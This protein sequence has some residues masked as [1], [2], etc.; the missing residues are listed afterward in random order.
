MNSGN[1]L[2]PLMNALNLL[3]RK[4]KQNSFVF[5]VSFDFFL[6]SVFVTNWTKLQRCVSLLDHWCNNPISDYLFSY[7]YQFKLDT[8]E[9]KVRVVRSII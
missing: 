8:I 7:V 6:Q 9:D 3:Y 5:R 1:R 2:S 4:L